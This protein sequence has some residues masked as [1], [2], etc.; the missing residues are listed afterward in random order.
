MVP[1]LLAAVGR[2]VA[3]IWAARLGHSARAGIFGIIGLLP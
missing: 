3:T 2:F 1:I